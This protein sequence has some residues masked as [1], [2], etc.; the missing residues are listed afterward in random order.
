MSIAGVQLAIPVSLLG[1]LSFAN[2]HQTR[3]LLVSSFC[4]SKEALPSQALNFSFLS[5]VKILPGWRKN[6]IS[7][8]VEFCFFTTLNTT[9]F[10][11]STRIVY[12][13]WEV[14]LSNL[15][16]SLN[17][18]VDCE[19]SLFCSKI[20]E[21][22]FQ[23]GKH[24]VPSCESQVRFDARRICDLQLQYWMF[25]VLKVRFNDF[26]EGERLLSV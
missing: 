19:Q 6:E 10:I 5:V 14:R 4:T 2:F 20:V 17:F 18:T 16:V 24:A 12:Y 23:N 25:A 21:T 1:V 7:R 26:R 22:N 9:Q 3:I 15:L 8:S 13:Y 11:E